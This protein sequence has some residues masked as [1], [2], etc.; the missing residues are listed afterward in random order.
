MPSWWRRDSQGIFLENI[1]V[2]KVM[3]YGEICGEMCYNRRRLSQ[4]GNCLSVADIF[5]YYKEEKF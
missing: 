4:A 2:Y 3:I 5:S 1:F